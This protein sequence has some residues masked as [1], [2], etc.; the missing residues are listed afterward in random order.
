ML[1]QRPSPHEPAADKLPPNNLAF[2]GLFPHDEFPE[3]TFADWFLP[4]YQRPKD[5]LPEDAWW[6][7]ACDASTATR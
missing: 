2:E 1:S 5:P 7:M 4:G 3:D 6:A